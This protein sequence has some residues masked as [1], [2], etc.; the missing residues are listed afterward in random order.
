M[1][2]CGC[3][4]DRVFRLNDNHSRFGATI[5][6]AEVGLQ[7]II[8]LSEFHKFFNFA[9]FFADPLKTSSLGTTV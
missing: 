6:K 9:K 3:L 4:A 8:Y 1:G 2:C 5:C 7:K